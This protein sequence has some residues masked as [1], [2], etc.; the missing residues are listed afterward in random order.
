MRDFKRWAPTI[1]RVSSSS[2]CVCGAG[3]RWKNS[4]NTNG[5]V[6]HK[7]SI[8]DEMMRGWSAPDVTSETSSSDESCVFFTEKTHMIHGKPTTSSSAMNHSNVFTFGRFVFDPN[9]LTNC[10]MLLLICKDTHRDL[11][12]VQLMLITNIH[13][14]S[15]DKPCRP[16]RD[17]ETRLWAYIIVVVCWP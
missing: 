2:Q 15:S 16:W 9:I 7:K 3:S 8:W 10:F 11:Y 5:V 17:V 6:C 4:G 14:A 1:H 13:Y 12:P